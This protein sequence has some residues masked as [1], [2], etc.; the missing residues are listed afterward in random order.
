MAGASPTDGEPVTSEL[1]GSGTEINI[2]LFADIRG[3][4]R[5]TQER[6]DEAAARL[7]AKFADIAR[8]GLGGK[9]ASGVEVRGDE[10]LAVFTSPRQ[11]L[12]AAVDLQSRFAEETSRDPTLPLRV[13]VGL[14]AGE[15]VP[16]EGGHRGGAL[17]VAARLCA[18]A[19]PGEV[20]ASQEVG[21]L[22]RRM[23]GVRFLEQGPL[24]LKGIAHPVHVIKVVVEAANPFKGLRPFD[25]ADAPDFFGREGLT[26]E[27]IARLS[28][29][30]ADARFLAIVGPSGSGKS[31]VV[32][33]GVLPALRQGALPGGTRCVVALMLPGHQ[34][35]KELAAVLERVTV[36]DRRALDE[37]L[38]GG[39]DLG[40]AVDG[41]LPPGFDLVLIVDQF[42]ELFTLVEDE[43]VRTAFLESLLTT[44]R[45]PSGRLRCIVTLRADLYDRPL[46][47][48]NF[49]DL[50][51]ARTQT[52]TPLSAEDL[53][54]AITGPA[55]RM[56][57]VVEPGLMAQM[58]ADVSDEPGALPILQYALTELFEQRRGN[59]MTL[60]AYRGIGG[61]AGALA[62]RAEAVYESL[63]DVQKRTARQLFLRLT[64]SVDETDVARRRVSRPELLSVHVDAT[65]METAID[66]FGSARL[67][68]FD[69]DPVSGSPTVEVAHEALLREWTRLRGWLEAAGEDLRTQ[70]R[71]AA[72]AREWLDAGRDLS[73]LVSGSR[74]E[75]FEAW[76][77]SSG[78]GVAPDEREFLEASLAERDR[79]RAE[80]EARDIRERALER[81]SLSRARALVVVLAAAAVAA[82]AVT[83]FAFSQRG[84]A[85]RVARIAQ[86]RELA[87]AAVANLETDAE[88]SVLLA[89]EAI[90]ET[91][92]VD[93]SVLPEAEEAL[94]RAVGA[95]RIVLSVPGVGGTLDWSRK[96]VFV[97]EG[98]EDKGIVD[99]RDAVTGKRVRAFLGHMVDIN[100]VAFDPDGSKLATTGDDDLLKVWDPTTGRLISSHR[101]TGSVFGPSFSPDGSLAAAAWSAEGLVRVVDPLRRRTVRT[102]SVPE[103]FGTAFSPDGRRIAIS[104]QESGDVAVFDLSTGTPA[105]EMKGHEFSV[106]AVSWSPDGRYIATA[107]ND[108]SS[109]VWD[110]RTGRLRFTLSGHKG[111]VLNVDWSPDSARVITGGSD[112]TALLWEI[113]EGGAR[114]VVTLSAQGLR[115]GAFGVFSPDEEKVMTGDVNVTNVKIWDVGLSGDAEW[116][117]LPT[118]ELWPDDVSFMPDGRSVAANGRRDSVTIWNLET[119]KALRTIGSSP[120]A[121]SATFEFQPFAPSPDGRSIAAA[122]LGEAK[123]WDTT[124]GREVLS[125]R[126]R[127]EVTDVDWSPDG[128]HLLAASS[129]GTATVVD[130]AGNEVRTLREEESF[131]VASARFSPNG[132]LV[133]TSV[134]SDRPSPENHLKIWDWQRGKVSRTIDN[135]AANVTVFDPR[136]ARLATAGSGGEARILDAASGATLAKLAGH[137][138]G[139]ED[140]AFSPDGSR[141][142]TAGFDGNVRVFNAD[143]GVQLL[144]LRGHSLGVFGVDFSPDGKKLASA[145]ADGSARVWALDLDD[146]IKIAKAELTR[147]LT[148][149]E[150]RQYL[151]VTRC[152]QAKR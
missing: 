26:Q 3:Y 126:H 18:V 117:K 56:G 91:R 86:A 115:G 150:C 44:V 95:S 52:V 132:R 142:A 149:E 35:L 25:E 105:F 37:F 2:F 54:R 38:H 76:R 57:V 16:L 139:I 110:G 101:G 127:D 47:Y 147:S 107:S 8:E 138:G 27:I 39:R 28:E 14:D 66:A 75:Q 85:E 83:V 63:D 77:E 23:E 148:D 15:A 118:Q 79:R 114:Q 123:V 45:Q 98:P 6:G 68:S 92:V 55:E 84:R 131:S 67:L 116:A 9:G 51:G 24:R 89:L 93:A 78:L 10:A 81:R 21:H 104:S 88:R 87:A 41:L 33:A 5:F 48:K 103:A 152:P 29:P 119:R 82:A 50:F 17:N 99:I 4:T 53:Q 11:A 80:D 7:A 62:R 40:S 124:T 111:L 134:V 113:D 102:L 121:R 128:K 137:S 71:L 32:R 31:S 144:V 20:L 30:G 129:D 125:Y 46:H 136:G 34:P 19:A 140:I 74:L 72:S 90:E 151:H 94:H 13:G 135:I 106:N 108:G 42:E 22:A 133:V 1:G 49:G 60:E 130:R 61:V 69:R 59:T 146:L 143:S 112:G 120:Q 96:G 12:R 97:T 36:G 65:A 109:K 43:P 58:V 122:G 70:R 145:S 141:V 64:T 73:F 100:A